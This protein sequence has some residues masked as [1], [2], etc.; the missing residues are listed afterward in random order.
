[1]I[2]LI[3]YV[4][5][6]VAANVITASTAPL[7]IGVFVIPWG[8]WFIGATFFLGDGIS[9]KRGRL[10]RYEAIGAALLISAFLSIFNGDLF[11]IT[12]ASTLAFAISE[13]TDTEI[14]HRYDASLPRRVFYS[15]AVGGLLDS[16]VFVVVGLS[17]LTTGIITWDQVFY[18]VLGQ[19]VIKTVLQALAAGVV[20]RRKMAVA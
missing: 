8:T 11:W 12:V 2:Y 4:A 9:V 18:A 3:L 7:I 6:V 5:S 20:S 14:F 19:W 10:V 15:G 13:A 16:T 1:M 17:P